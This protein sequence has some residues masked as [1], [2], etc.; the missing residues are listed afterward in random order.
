LVA[1]RILFKGRV[2]PLSVEDGSPQLSQFYPARRLVALA[3]GVSLGLEDCEPSV[4]L[5]DFGKRGVE[6]E[7]EDSGKG[8]AEVE[9]EDFGKGGVEVEPEGFGKGGVEAEPEGFGRG[10][11]E[12]EPE[13]FG[14]GGV[15]VEVESE[16]DLELRIGGSVG[17][18]GM[19]RLSL[20]TVQRV[21]W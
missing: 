7:P 8:G 18:P 10:G 19:G 6:V 21:R 14:K 16:Y 4:E 11:V 20:L 1:S 9:P 2:R 12:V 15:R 13:G 5:E 3:L 17:R